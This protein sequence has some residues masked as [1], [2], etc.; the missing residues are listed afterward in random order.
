MMSLV[1]LATLQEDV[2]D[3]KYESLD[4]ASPFLASDTRMVKHY[5]SC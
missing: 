4:I 5:A 3:A 1:G 2:V